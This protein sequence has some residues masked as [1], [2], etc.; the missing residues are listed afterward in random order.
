VRVR[1]HALPSRRSSV[2]E[3][4]ST[5]LPPA[6][7]EAFESCVRQLETFYAMFSVSLDEALELRRTG[8][9]GQS[10]RA[11]FVIPALCARLARNVEGLLRTLGE[12]AKHFGIIPNTA[13]LDASN[14]RGS[15]EQRTARMNDLLSHVLLT[16]RSQFLHKV[17]TLEE[18]VLCIRKH[19]CEVASDLGSG[20]S[21]EPSSDWRA[22]DDA[23][24]D[25]NTCLREA[26]VLLKSFIVVLP[27]DQLGDFQK[28]VSAQMLAP[29]DADSTQRRRMVLIERQ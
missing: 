29:Y 3:D 28:T 13:P 4:W 2:Q 7:A 26:I 20:V 11:I 6:K 9:S 15:R 17:D 16:Q 18:M 21:E 22:L 19:F 1:P 27:D 23:H 25:L 24:F 12:H 10:C 14:F 5:W 8:K